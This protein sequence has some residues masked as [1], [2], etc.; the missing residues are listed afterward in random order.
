MKRLYDRMLEEIYIK[1]AF[2]WGIDVAIK[3][4]RSIFYAS[5]FSSLWFYADNINWTDVLLR[6]E[7]SKWYDIPIIYMLVN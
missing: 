1:F 4:H 5:E 3:N 2:E 7:S 6:T